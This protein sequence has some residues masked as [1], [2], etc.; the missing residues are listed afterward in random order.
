MIFAALVLAAT[1]DAVPRDVQPFVEKQTTVLAVERGDLNRDGRE[2]A[3]VVLE[4][5]DPEQSR[6]LLILVRDEKGALRLAK[7]SAKI[8]GCHDCGGAMGDPFQGVT[9]EK[10]RFT[11]EHYGGS[12]WRWSSSFTFGW[13]RR[14]ASWQLIR[15]EHSSFHASDP[16]SE[17]TTVHTPPK[18]FGLI[19]VTELDPEHYLG[20]GRK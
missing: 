9:I 7:R 13:S 15:V 1:A 3:I 8:V 10:G 20:R 6:P 17:K 4:P 12:S 14:D 5:R 16:D 18:D 2:D 11:V 19:D